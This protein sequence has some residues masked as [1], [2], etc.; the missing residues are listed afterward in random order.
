M[1]KSQPVPVLIPFLVLVSAIFI[2]ILIYAYVETKKANPQMIEV[3]R[4]ARPLPDGHGS[5]R[6][7]DRK[8][9]VRATN[10]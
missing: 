6:S 4:A 1:K 8:G 3:G 10:V 2:G 7:R 9:A 5:D